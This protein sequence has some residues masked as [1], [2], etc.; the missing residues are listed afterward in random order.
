MN[1]K[2]KY[3]FSKEK[4][5]EG[6]KHVILLEKMKKKWEE[7]RKKAIKSRKKAPQKYFRNITHRIKYAEGKI[8]NIND[9][10][11]EFNEIIKKGW[12]NL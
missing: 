4:I 11:Q 2:M 3:E 9:K 10:I 12:I 8:D 6:K 1:N 7:E 5:E